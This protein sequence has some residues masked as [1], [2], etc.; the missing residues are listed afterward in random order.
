MTQ[1]VQA[2]KTQVQGIGNKLYAL[3]GKHMAGQHSLTGGEAVCAVI[4]AIMI[5]APQLWSK[6]PFAGK[7]GSSMIAFAILVLALIVW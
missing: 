1:Q 7:F 2:V 6:I 4:A 5:F 3:G